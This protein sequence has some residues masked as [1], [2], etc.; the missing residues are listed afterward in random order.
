[1]WKMA[2]RHNRTALSRMALWMTT[3]PSSKFLCR[4]L[5]ATHS[6]RR[7]RRYVTGVWTLLVLAV[8]KGGEGV[9][10]LLNE[11]GHIFISVIYIVWCVQCCLH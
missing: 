6:C 9:I 2:T 5:V 1:M 11:K 8:W 4:W 10:T 3:K 7:W